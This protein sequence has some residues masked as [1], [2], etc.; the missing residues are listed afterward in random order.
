MRDV[1]YYLWALPF[2]WCAC[3]PAAALQ[4]LARSAASAQADIT[5][6]VS[7]LD[8]L[9]QARAR[10]QAELAPCRAARDKARAALRR[11]VQ[12]WQEVSR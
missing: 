8:E 4:P 5:D 1:L 9:C 2:L 6:A 12:A 10:D 3:F 7:Q 11:E